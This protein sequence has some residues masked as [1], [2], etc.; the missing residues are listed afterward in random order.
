MLV[1]PVTNV[2][3]YKEEYKERILNDEEI[4]APL[5]PLGIP[6]YEVSSF[7]HT[8]KIG[9]TNILTQTDDAFKPRVYFSVTG[10]KIS[11]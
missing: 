7:G 8:R 1:Q 9:K 2:T 5:E 3:V 6:N 4:W 11:L 10:V